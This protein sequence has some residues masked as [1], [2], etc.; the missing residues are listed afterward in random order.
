MQNRYGWSFV[1]KPVA[2]QQVQA[3]T[4]QAPGTAGV[5]VPP[6][7]PTLTGTGFQLPKFQMPNLQM[8]NLQIPGS[9]FQQAFDTFLQGRFGPSC[10][11][12]QCSNIK[13]KFWQAAVTVAY[14][15][16]VHSG[17]IHP[18]D[19]LDKM[20]GIIPGVSAASCAPPA[21]AALPLIPAPFPPAPLTLHAAQSP[22]GQD[23]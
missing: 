5:V 8:P 20:A 13:A 16:S 21:P 15:K 1:T 10:T 19:L 9:N 22:A 23:V 11:D 2:G 18:G 6:V 7:D 12:P 4:G 14:I 3:P 17:K